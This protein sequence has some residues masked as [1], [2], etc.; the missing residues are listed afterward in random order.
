VLTTCSPHNFELVKAYGVDEVFDYHNKEAC[1]KAIKSSVGDSLGYAYVCVMGEDAPAVCLPFK[2]NATFTDTTRS[3][4]K[5]CLL[6]EASSS[7]SPV[8]HRLVRML[9]AR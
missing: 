5:S 3:A 2:K 1:V 8:R 4:A 7:Q 9:K 6:P